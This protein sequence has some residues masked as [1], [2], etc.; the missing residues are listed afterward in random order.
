MRIETKLKIKHVFDFIF[1]L[2]GLVLLLPLLLLIGLFIRVD[3]KGPVLF[4][5]ERVGKDGKLFKILKFRTMLHRKRL[6]HVEIEDDNPELTRMGKFLRK[7]KI[8]EL[9]QLFNVLKGDMS[10]VGPRPTLLEQVVKY[11]PWQRT[12]LKMRPGMTGWAQIKGGNHLPWETRIEYDNFYIK[13][14]SFGLDIRILFETPFFILKELGIRVR[15][16]DLCQ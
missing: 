6:Q 14:W 7:T 11:T 16:K 8:D 1:S 9:P 15:I 10:L 4:I 5:Q 12:R 3:S 13:N 2:V